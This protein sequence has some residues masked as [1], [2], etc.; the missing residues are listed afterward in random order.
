MFWNCPRNV[1][2][3]YWENPAKIFQ[4]SSQLFP[5]NVPESFRI[6]PGKFL[7]ISRIVSGHVLDFFWTC[8]VQEKFPEV[9]G[10]V[11]GHFRKNGKFQN[12]SRTSPRHLPEHEQLVNGNETIGKQNKS[13]NEKKCKR[14]TSEKKRKTTVQ[15]KFRKKISGKQIGN[16]I[17]FAEHFRKKR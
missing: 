6:C 7:E 13:V 1:P 8:P 12:R 17:I 2:E 5:G 9:S 10:T 11:S 16:K 3:M 15:Q 14:T 4:I